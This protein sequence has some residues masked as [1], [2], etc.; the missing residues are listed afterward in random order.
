M[1]ASIGA[2][3]SPIDRSRSSESIPR[4][5]APEHT[6]KKKAERSEK[7]CLELIFNNNKTFCARRR[8]ALF[9]FCF[10]RRS[11]RPGAC[12][13]RRQQLH[14]QGLEFG[15]KVRQPIAKKT[16]VAFTIYTPNP[17]GGDGTP[18][19]EIRPLRST[20]F[21]FADRK[22][23]Q[24]PKIM[25][26]YFCMFFLRFS[27]VFEVHRGFCFP[28]KRDPPHLISFFHN[29]QLARQGRTNFPHFVPSVCKW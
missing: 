16:N 23:C 28:A 22:R 12:D 8:R 6:K 10:R 14:F 1:V 7:N 27:N 20:A 18:P 26:V 25:N 17:T 15:K 19:P 9:L 11:R 4:V 5:S 21:S 24:P 13:K 2:E 3:T 29:A